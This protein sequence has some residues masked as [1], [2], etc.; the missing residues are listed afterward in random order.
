MCNMHTLSTCNLIEISHY[1]QHGLKANTMIQSNRKCNCALHLK[2]VEFY[3]ILLHQ[4][5]IYLYMNGFKVYALTTNSTIKN[6][7]N[8]N[9]FSQTQVASFRFKTKEPQFA[10]VVSR[11]HFR[12]LAASQVLN[13]QQEDNITWNP[14]NMFLRNVHH[15]Y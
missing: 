2:R 4:I 8:I 5:K 1:T 3:T 7:S 6:S 9:K 12:T 13:K 14:W 15:L 10:H 11:L